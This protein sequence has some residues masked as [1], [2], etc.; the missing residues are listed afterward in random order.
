MRGEQAG[1]K[2]LLSVMPKGWEDKAKELGALVRGREIKNALDLLRLVFL[3]LTEGKSFSGT[4]ALLQPASI[5]SISKK[6][7]F[8]RFQTCGEWLRWLCESI[9]RNNKAIREPPEWLG[10]QKVY[11]VDASDEP[12]HGSDK[13]DYRL[14]YAIGLFD[15]G[16]KEMALTGTE[17]GEKVSNFKSFGAGDIVI[18]DRGYCSKQGIECLLERGSGFLFRFGTKRFQVYT[19]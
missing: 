13:A 12:V 14:H 1:F 19:Q 11:L 15:L 3:Y 8:T 6:A 18:G 10:D 5:C 17:Q 9:Y 16:M 2:R 7:V 4:A